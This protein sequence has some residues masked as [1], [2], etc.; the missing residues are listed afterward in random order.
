MYTGEKRTQKL[1]EFRRCIEKKLERYG[2]GI[3][4]EV[5]E[6]FSD[7]AEGKVTVILKKGS[8]NVNRVTS[9]DEIEDIQKVEWIEKMLQ[10]F[11]F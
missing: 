2:D 7:F 9:Y 11:G 4:F 1:H 6:G 10:A 8:V 5:R 3:D